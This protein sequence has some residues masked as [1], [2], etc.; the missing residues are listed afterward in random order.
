MAEDVYTLLVQVGRQ[1]GDG[2]PDAATGGALLCY[3][4]GKDEK[5][6]V[7]ATVALMRDAGL[8]PLEV[9][10]YGSRADRL[11]EGE[12]I[13][14]EDAA[15]MDRALDENAVIVVQTTVFED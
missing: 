10:S 2:L 15:L 9:E 3:A 8:A 7:D 1:D 11:A 14:A 13:A 12:E 4:A 5:A 6:A